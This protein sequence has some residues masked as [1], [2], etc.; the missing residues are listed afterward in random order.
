M[1][2]IHIFQ[3]PDA[4]AVGIVADGAERA[5]GFF[6]FFRRNRLSGIYAMNIC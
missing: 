2:G 1:V 4:T 6:L 3:V 5:V